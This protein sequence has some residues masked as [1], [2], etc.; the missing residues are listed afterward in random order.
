MTGLYARPNG[1]RTFKDGLCGF[2][3]T[4]PRLELVTKEEFDALD[5]YLPR[6]I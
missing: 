1:N 6:G 3:F 5:V 4:V 2:V